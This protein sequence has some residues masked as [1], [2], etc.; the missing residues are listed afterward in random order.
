MVDES[1]DGSCIIQVLFF[2]TRIIAH[3]NKRFVVF[4]R[5]IQKMEWLINLAVR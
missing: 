4:L 3:F 1:N 5:K 2:N